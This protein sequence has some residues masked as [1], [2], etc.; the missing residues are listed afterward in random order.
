MH[1]SWKMSKTI[2]KYLH[3][4][5]QESMFIAANSEYHIAPRRW[6]KSEGLI[7]LR[8]VRNIQQMPRS[9]G[10]IVVATYKQGLRNTLPATFHAIQRMFGLKPEKHFYVGRKAPPKSNFKTP[11]INP[12][13]YEHAIHWYNGSITH[14]VSQDIPYTSNSLT[15]DY[16]IGDEAKT[17]SYDKLKDETFPANSGLP[18]FQ[19]CPWHCGMLF[20]T[21]QPTSKSGQWLWER[22]KE[23]DIEL[24]ETIQGL[25]YD[26]WQ[27]KQIN[28]SESHIKRLENDLAELRKF[29]TLYREKEYTIFD[30]IE[31]VTEN[32]VKRQKRDLPPITFRTSILNRRMRKIENGF[33]A[34]LN[35]KIHCYDAYDNSFL[36]AQFRGKDGD[37][38]YNRDIKENSLQ[39]GD[40]DTEKPISVAFDPNSAISWCIVGQPDYEKQRLYTLKAFFAKTPRKTRE[41]C[42]AVADYYCYHPNRN[43]IFNY[44]STLIDSSQE[45]DHRAVIIDAFTNRGWNVIENFIG[46]PARHHTKQEQI[47]L[48]MKGVPEVKGVKYL[49][50]M[51][52]RQH[53]EFLLLAMDQTGIIIGGKDGFRKNKSGEKEPDSVEDPTELRTDSTDAWDTLWIGSTFY[54][55]THT[56]NYLPSSFPK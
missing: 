20:V 37:I 8:L 36:D 28:A 46:A 27:L 54:P 22:E 41:V 49:F 44:D 51:F 39:D 17:L 25:I 21:D 3:P 48:A 31:I 35:D 24:I 52:N 26:I 30:N 14:L 15:L 34:S 43:I 9:A 11:Y 6:G 16:I 56:S 47:D 40:V 33:Y 19:D 55:K 45:I 32:Y 53:N 4:A 10:A 50:P 1:I 38:L 42:N 12:F 18:Y 7:A 29:A 5:Q 2:K 13:T 23:M